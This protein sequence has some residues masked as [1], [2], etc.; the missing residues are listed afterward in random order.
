MLPGAANPLLN[1]FLTR[2]G[3]PHW[4]LH[5]LKSAAAT[6]PCLPPHIACV[7]LLLLPCSPVSKGTPYRTS[8]PKSCYLI[9][10]LVI[11]LEG[12]T[13]VE[14]LWLSHLAA[15]LEQAGKGDLLLDGP[16]GANLH[17]AA[18]LDLLLDIERKEEGHVLDKAGAK[19]LRSHRSGMHS[20]SRAVVPSAKWS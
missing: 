16:L 12:T 10:G 6:T 18:V 8:S 3:T 14:G 15:E 13:L 11:I 9:K 17:T 2:C 20:L 4:V 1:P 5:L 7:S 19:K